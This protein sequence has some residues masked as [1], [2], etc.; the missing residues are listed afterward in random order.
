MI[1]TKLFE[2]AATWEVK[3]TTRTIIRKFSEKLKWEKVLEISPGNKP[4]FYR[5]QH[6]YCKYADYFSTDDVVKNNHKRYGYNP[7]NN[8]VEIDF[9]LKDD[10]VL[11]E[12]DSGSL[13]AC[14]SS[15]VLEHIPDPIRHFM[16]ISN[17]LM[18]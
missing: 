13:N 15:H 6:Q 14:S 1:K 3:K 10:P 11:L 4:I 17:K 9:S 2:L 8:F 7:A 12:V 5:Q 16:L 18:H